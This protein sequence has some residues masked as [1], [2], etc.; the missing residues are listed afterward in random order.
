MA[1]RLLPFFLNIIASGA[2]VFPAILPNTPSQSKSDYVSD[3]HPRTRTNL[4]LKRGP[5]SAPR[6]P[7]QLFLPPHRSRL[8]ITTDRGAS[9]M[10]RR[11]PQSRAMVIHGWTMQALHSNESAPDVA[12]RVLLCVIPADPEVVLPTGRSG[13]DSNGLSQPPDE[14]IITSGLPPEV[15]PTALPAGL[16]NG[17][18]VRR[19]R[20]VSQWYITCLDKSTR[21]PKSFRT[22]SP[23]KIR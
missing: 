20:F 15:T 16:P 23:R 3:P 18:S 13:V 17:F 22:P 6:R 2:L 19:T 11:R 8:T 12:S 4:R 9:S 1:F 5:S 7:F 10:R 21:Q 14:G